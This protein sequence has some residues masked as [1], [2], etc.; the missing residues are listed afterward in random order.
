M[1]LQNTVTFND[2]MT[3]IDISQSGDEIIV[4]PGIY[5]ENLVIKEFFSSIIS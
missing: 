4:S 5:N 2:I 1:G 3:L